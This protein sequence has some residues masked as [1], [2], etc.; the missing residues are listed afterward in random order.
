AKPTDLES[1]WNRPPRRTRKLKARL[2]TLGTIMQAK[3]LERRLAEIHGA[4]EGSMG[5]V[6]AYA[7]ILEQPFW[8]RP[9]RLLRHG[10]HRQ[11]AGGKFKFA[12]LMALL[13]GT[14]PDRTSSR[15]PATPDSALDPT[16]DTG[17]E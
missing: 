13:R 8:L 9:I 11:T 7:T 5:M 15:G 12:I 2:H 6:N 1:W 4:N 16:T 14:V 3:A 17:V 10:I